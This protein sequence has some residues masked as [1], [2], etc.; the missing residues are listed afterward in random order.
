[1]RCL[2]LWCKTTRETLIVLHPSTF[3]VFTPRRGHA[4]FR[5]RRGTVLK[6]GVSAPPPTPHWQMLSHSLNAP[7]ER[8]QVFQSND[9]RAITDYV[10]R[11]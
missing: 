1:M 9:I 4:P 5:S 8:V 3:I 6:R 10:S 11:T 2:C 7:P